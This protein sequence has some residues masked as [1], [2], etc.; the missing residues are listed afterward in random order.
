MTVSDSSRTR[1]VVLISG[2]GSNLQALIDARQA[3]QMSVD[4]VAV[5]SNRPAARGLVR[6][7]QAGVTAQVV[8]HTQ[9]PDREAFDRALAGE[10]DR[11]SPDLIV[12]AGFMRI[13]TTEFTHHYLGRLLNIHPSLLPKY[14]GLHTHER[15]LAAGDREHGATVHFVT[16][17]LDG[18]PA[19]VQAR[20]PIAPGDDAASLAQRVQAQEHRIYPLAVKWFAEGRLR[21]EN[22]VAFLD[23]E[24]LGPSGHLISDTQPQQS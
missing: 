11:Y 23:S 9:Y 8:D 13:L 19:V 4:L 20:V 22:G 1:V 5:I 6:A 10:I 18:G 7:Q 14:Q 16:A 24:P 17:E 3:G 2:N 21:M 15:A 12:L